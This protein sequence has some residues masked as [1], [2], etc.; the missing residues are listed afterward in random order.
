[1]W[2]DGWP[3]MVVEVDGPLELHELDLTRESDAPSE[4]VGGATLSRRGPW[5]GIRRSTHGWPLELEPGHARPW[6]FA[7]VPSHAG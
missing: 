5:I 6:L 3:A 4:Y 2:L 7:L 1:M